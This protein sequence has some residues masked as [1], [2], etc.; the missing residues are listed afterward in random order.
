MPIAR[1]LSV[2]NDR[3]LI[4]LIILTILIFAPIYYY[5]IYYPVDSDF[6]THLLF[7]RY[8][9]HGNIAQIP[10]LNRANL[11]LQLLLAGLYFLS[12][13]KV[14]LGIMLTGI[15]T[16]S[17]VM[18]AVIIYI[19]LGSGVKRY[20]DMGRAFIAGTLTLV[21]PLMLFAF[22]DKLYYF[23]YIDLANY[24]NPTVI[25]VR[26]FAL[27][28]FL[29]GV[30]AFTE[31][32]NSGKLI[33]AA[34][35]L[36]VISALVKPNYLLCILPALFIL[37]MWWMFLHKAVDFRYLVFG[38]MVPSIIVLGIQ[39]LMVYSSPARQV[40]HIIFS[41]L[42]VESAF[43]GDL[44]PKFILSILFPVSIL[45]ADFRKFRDKP[46]LLLALIGFTVSAFQVYFL[47]ES[48]NRFYDGNFR[49]GAQ[50]MLF[51]WFVISAREFI[52][53]IFDGNK[54]KRER[55]ILS[56]VYFSYLAA[57]VVYYAYC[58]LSTTYA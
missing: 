37:T 16:L 9:I 56:T 4:L 1:F 50:V 49:W 48:G 22:H 47:A 17:Q 5:R 12:L 35:I 34:S 55:I 27:V 39:W 21:A 43:S 3:T 31:I 18:T 41:P 57:G 19:W 7:T 2:I 36:V 54:S 58:F 33:L 51:I 25:L 14:P 8:L 26:P 6:S 28:S 29:I 52:K 44:F 23:G 24:H 32:H 40:S 53:I 20:W 42:G 30:R 11:G 10:V 46:D 45:V 38:F 13:H 15:L